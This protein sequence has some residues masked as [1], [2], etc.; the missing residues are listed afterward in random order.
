VDNNCTVQ[1]NPTG[2]A[3]RFS[4]KSFWLLIMRSRFRPRFYRADF[5]LKVEDSHFDHGLC[6]L[7]KL[8]FKA[9]SGASYSYITIHL[10]GTT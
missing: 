10:F 7:V 6:G 9:P 1:V 3:S 8:R 4:G 2:P 5:T